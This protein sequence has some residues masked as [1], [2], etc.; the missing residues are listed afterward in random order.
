[1]GDYGERIKAAREAANMTQEQLGK[2][3]GVT[4]VTIMRY[5]K[6]QREPTQKTLRRLADVLG[7]TI[8]YLQGYES[9]EA[10]AIIDALKRKDSRELESLLGL[11]EDSIIDE[12]FEPKDGAG[13]SMFY[14]RDKEEAKNQAQLL[15]SFS[16]LNSVGQQEAIKRVGEL[17]EISKYQR[18]ASDLLP[19]QRNIDP[20]SATLSPLRI[21]LDEEKTPSQPE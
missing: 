6:D 21:Y 20:S 18:P 14:A 2:E 5:E 11:K 9:I 1:M 12:D 10:R 7:V 13:I 19:A 8:G 17:A 15:Y 4:G 3:I 16:Y